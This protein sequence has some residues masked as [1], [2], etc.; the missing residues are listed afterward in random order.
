[1]NAVGDVVHILM[2][3][4]ALNGTVQHQ[5]E[6]AWRYLRFILL[7]VVEHFK[8][9]LRRHTPR[10]HITL[11]VTQTKGAE[12]LPASNTTDRLTQQPITQTAFE[13]PLEHWFLTGSHLVKGNFSYTFDMVFAEQ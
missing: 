9:T 13:Q 6:K 1:M 8:L 4:E 3:M 7:T 2:A 10:T 5:V 12:I 11:L